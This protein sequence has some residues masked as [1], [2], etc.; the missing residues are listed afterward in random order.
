MA[1]KLIYIPD[2]Y[3]QNYNFCGLK[4][5]DTQNSIEVPKMLNQRIR[6]RYYKTLGTSIIKSPMSPPPQKGI[7]LFLVVI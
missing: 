1:D 3:T 7:P 5:L 2:H 6:K 4:R